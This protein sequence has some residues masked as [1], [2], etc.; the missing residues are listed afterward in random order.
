MCDQN[1]ASGRI[2]PDVL[3]EFTLWWEGP[4]WLP[5]RNFPAS[6]LIPETAEELKGERKWKN[7]EL[8][9]LAART[10][11]DKPPLIGLKAQQSLTKT[12]RVVTYLNRF[13]SLLRSKKK[14]PG[15]YITTDEC[16]DAMTFL[17]LEA[18][19]FFYADE[20]RTLAN[21]T[22][23]KKTS[24]TVKIYPFLYDGLLYVGGRLR[25]CNC[26]SSMK[27]QRIIP[28]ESELAHLVV[29]HA[30]RQTLHGGT[31]QTIAYIR[32]KFWIPSC[33]SLVRKLLLSC[34]TC[35]RFTAQPSHPLMGDLPKD[36]VE[37]PKRAFQDVGLDFAGAFWCRKGLQMTEKVY[38]A[39]PV[40]FASKAVYLELLS[41]LKA[42]GC[43]AALRGFIAKRGAPEVIYSDNGSNFVGANSEIE[44]FQRVLEDQ[45][46]TSLQAEAAGLNL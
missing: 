33:R 14:L 38:M 41:D 23:V 27:Y 29:L 37:V 18:Q 10:K 45:H 34:V 39:L 26:P 46:Q 40:C 17:I 42:Q 22:Q 36:R 9:A 28:Q 24:R 1:V 15:P 13:V 6:P 30:H 4:S 8:F 5:K 20:L 7:P 25:Q 31:T 19:Q 2:N 35:S 44:A 11:E 32:S 43:L 21:E 16:C 12:L 3:R